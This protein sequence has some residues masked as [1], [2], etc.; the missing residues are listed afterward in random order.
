MHC[1]D[2]AERPHP[3]NQLSFMLHELVFLGYHS[4]FASYTY[5]SQRIRIV[6]FYNYT[7]RLRGNIF[8]Y[9]C[10]SNENVRQKSVLINKQWF[11]ISKCR[12]G[13]TRRI[14]VNQPLQPY[15]AATIRMRSDAV[16]SSVVASRMKTFNKNKCSSTNSGPF[17]TTVSLDVTDGYM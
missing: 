14:H 8:L 16:F 7:L 3:G 1:L 9:R 4:Q 6:K 12:F 17:Q 11:F 2:Y 15:I 5:T 10:F 13:R